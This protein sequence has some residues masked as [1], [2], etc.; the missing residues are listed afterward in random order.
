[1]AKKKNN[2]EEIDNSSTYI[3][4]CKL[5]CGYS[6][7]LPDGRKLILNGSNHKND[8]GATL[9]I[10]GYGRTEVAIA[11]WDYVMKVYGS[12]RLFSEDNP[13]IFAAESKKEGDEIAR[14]VGPHV[15]SGME[16]RAPRDIIK[17]AERQ[18]NNTNAAAG[19]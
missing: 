12:M 15:K 6:V 10:V 18:A 1:M 8:D 7:P 16:Q 5:P 2:N 3:V 13:V 17:K 9:T 11:D 4:Y 19:E 14:D